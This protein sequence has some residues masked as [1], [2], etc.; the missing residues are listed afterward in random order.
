MNKSEYF[1]KKA[2][3]IKPKDKAL[4]FDLALIKQDFAQIVIDQPPEI[5]TIE[6]IKKALN[7]LEVSKKYFSALKNPKTKI[8]N[9]DVSIAGKREEHNETVKKALL[10]KL[11]EQEKIEKEKIERMNNINSKS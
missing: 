9:Y 7:G 4:Q 1:L 10:Q 6:N 3:F 8:V 2:F 5:R 11:E